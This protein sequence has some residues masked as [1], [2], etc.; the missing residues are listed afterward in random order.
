ML[1]SVLVVG[2]PPPHRP[3]RFS[4]PP[5]SGQSSDLTVIAVMSGGVPPFEVQ[6]RDPTLGMRASTGPSARR[7]TRPRTSA[8]DG[9][10][11]TNGL[12]GGL[13]HDPSDR[14]SRHSRLFGPGVS[15]AQLMAGHR[16]FKKSAASRI[17]KH[18]ACAYG[19]GIARSLPSRVGQE[20]ALRAPSVPRKCVQI[21]AH[22][23][24]APASRRY[25]P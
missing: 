13:S 20:D 8:A 5:G 23:T 4:I 3:T 7:S 9:N 10:V 1:V 6:G 22:S 21:G 24:V 12:H 19:L 18:S 16:M 11:H 14:C 2:H 17:A 15:Q 25:K